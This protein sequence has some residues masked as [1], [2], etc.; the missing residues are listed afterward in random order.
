MVWRRKRDYTRMRRCSFDGIV[1]SGEI[2]AQRIGSYICCAALDGKEY[3]Q[4]RERNTGIVTIKM[5]CDGLGIMLPDFFSAPAFRALEQEIK[6][7][8][9]SLA[10]QMQTTRSK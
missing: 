7:H 8:E 6:Q 2:V 5:L 1:R 3:H 4:R 10:G 9:Y